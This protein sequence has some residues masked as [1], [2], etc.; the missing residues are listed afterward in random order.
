MGKSSMVPQILNEVV[1]NIFQ[2]DITESIVQRIVD[3]LDEGSCAVDAR[4]N[5]G[6]REEHPTKFGAAARRGSECRRVRATNRGIKRRGG[7][8][9][10]FP[11]PHL[12]AYT[13]ASM[14]HV[15][16]DNVGHS[17]LRNVD[18]VLDITHE[19]TQLRCDCAGS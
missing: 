5:R 14:H 1:Q 3:R 17:V 6:S 16:D 2:E 19:R 8:F 18:T 12:G 4:I 15:V 9:K 13:D 7:P 10:S 11:G